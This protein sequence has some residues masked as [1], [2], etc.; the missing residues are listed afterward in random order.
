MSRGGMLEQGERTRAEYASATMP[1]LCMKASSGFVLSYEKALKRIWLTT[2]LTLLLASRISRS[3][4]WKLLTPID[5]TRPCSWSETSSAQASG[6]RP[7][8]RLAL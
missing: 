4:I 5:L 6:M 2:G 3:L 7:T 1:C 8:T